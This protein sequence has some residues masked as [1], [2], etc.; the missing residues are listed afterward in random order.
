MVHTQVRSL[1]GWQ[2]SGRR[3][4]FPL[5]A[6]YRLAFGAGGGDR[7]NGA[8]F[9]GTLSYCCPENKKKGPNTSP[10][11]TGTIPA[12]GRHKGSFLQ[13]EG[14]RG[15]CS[16]NRSR[17]CHT[18]SLQNIIRGHIK[19]SKSVVVNSPG[20]TCLTDQGELW[21]R[22]RHF[23]SICPRVGGLQLFVLPNGTP[24]LTIGAASFGLQPIG[25]QERDY[26]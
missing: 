1:Q 17:L 14:M 26:Y 21:K 18:G 5:A 19:C 16:N 12:K 20:D 2:D 4:P 13:K 9:R 25:L 6:S 15:H 24:H 7:T 3:V 22:H 23:S 10:H 8:S 11:M